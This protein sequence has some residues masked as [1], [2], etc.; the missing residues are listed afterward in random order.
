LIRT[1]IFDFDGVLADTEELMLRFSAIACF[2]L[3]YPC[4]P[5]RAHLEATEPMSFANL[6]R[7]L[8]LPE[9]AIPA[10]VQRSLELFHDNPDPLKVF[11]GMEGVLVQAAMQARIGIVS[12]NTTITIQKFLGDHHLTHTVETILGVDAPGTKVE[13]INQMIEGSGWRDDA[14]FIGDTA[15]DVRAAR[16]SSVA[17]IAVTWGHHSR[18]KLIEAAPDYLVDTP[19]ELVAV[20]N[21]MKF[22]GSYA[23]SEPSIIPG[24]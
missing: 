1:I 5:S 11:P 18:Q 9:A 2:E 15:S 21:G 7:Q 16:E 22:G 13:K 17:S 24:G 6:G 19:E 23:D 10:Y 8:G 12:G 14:A 3:G 4:Q 20:L